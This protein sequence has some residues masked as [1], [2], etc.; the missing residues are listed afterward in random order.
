MFAVLVGA[1]A[2]VVSDS[3]CRKYLLPMLEEV[4]IP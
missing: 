3:T 1:E 2:K 4:T